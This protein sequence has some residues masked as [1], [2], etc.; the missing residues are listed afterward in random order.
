MPPRFDLASISPRNPPPAIA[1]RAIQHLHQLAAL[2]L[3]H[4]A[5]VAADLLEA[6]DLLLEGEGA[7]VAPEERADQLAAQ[8]LQVG[9][10]REQLAVVLEQD[11]LVLDGLGADAAQQCLVA[12]ELVQRRR[13]GPQQPRPQRAEQVV[14]RRVLR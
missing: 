9:L 13:A 14:L 12:L 11:A 7:A 1:A 6:A 8:A 5:E 10:E 2:A 3:A 4:A